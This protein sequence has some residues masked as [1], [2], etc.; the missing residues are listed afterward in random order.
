MIEEYHDQLVSDFNGKLGT[1]FSFEVDWGVIPEDV[2]GW[3]WEDDNLKKCYYNSYFLPLETKLG[4]LFEDSMYKDEINKQVQTI[5][6]VPGRE[7]VADF[8]FENGTFFVKHKMCVN[9]LN[10]EGMFLDAALRGIG[11]TI[12]SKLS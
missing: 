10:P 5:S 3:N 9:Q 1:Q 11:D 6:F 12:D 2:D 8:D 7:M 4:E